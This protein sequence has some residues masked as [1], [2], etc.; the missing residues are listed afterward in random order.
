MPKDWI[1]VPKGRVKDALA[2]AVY[3]LWRNPLGGSAEGIACELNPELYFLHLDRE[4]LKILGR[5]LIH[6]MSEKGDLPPS[7]VADGWDPDRFEFPYVGQSL[8]CRR[9]LQRM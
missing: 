6:K 5:M 7:W 4:N 9:V 1:V 2:V 3:G 8:H